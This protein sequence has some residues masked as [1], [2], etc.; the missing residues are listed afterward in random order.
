MFLFA[1]LGAN[2]AE[3]RLCPHGPADEASAYAR[4]VGP[5]ED[6]H[7]HRKL[8]LVHRCCVRSFFA[9]MKPALCPLVPHD[10]ASSR[11]A[12]QGIQVAG[13]VHCV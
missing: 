6:V 7:S 5:D 3:D 10:P 12:V 13:P 8:L 9:P 1:Q 2:H 4:M 11:H